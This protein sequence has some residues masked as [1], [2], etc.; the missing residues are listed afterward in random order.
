[1]KKHLR[2]IKENEGDPVIRGKALKVLGLPEDATPEEMTMAFMRR[3]ED[4]PINDHHRLAI[5]I[6]EIFKGWEED[7]KKNRKAA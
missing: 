4:D 1:M 5:E 7:R 2:T 3:P 6:R